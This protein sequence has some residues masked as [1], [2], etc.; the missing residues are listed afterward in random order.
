MTVI[1][2]L[3]GL[4]TTGLILILWAEY[5]EHE[6]EM[7]RFR[8]QTERTKDRIRDLLSIENKYEIITKKWWF[9]LFF[10]ESHILGKNKK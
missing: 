1:T 2:I 3:I 5:L 9:K 7:E 8:Q 6:D 4:L 10:R